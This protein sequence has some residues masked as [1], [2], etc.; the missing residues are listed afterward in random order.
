MSPK[1][2]LICKA[3]VKCHSN[4]KLNSYCY[5]RDIKRVLKEVGVGFEAFKVE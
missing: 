5:L 2:G 3:K 1:W 4:D